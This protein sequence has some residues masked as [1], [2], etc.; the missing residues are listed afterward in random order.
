M[1]RLF[2]FDID[3]FVTRDVKHWDYEN[4]IPRWD[5]I[6]F[7]RRLSKKG[8]GV[9][10]QSH[11][12]RRD[13]EATKDW[14]AKFEVP[15]DK[16]ELLGPTVKKD[17]I[18]WDDMNTIIYGLD[19]LRFVVPVDIATNSMIRATISASAAASRIAE[20]TKSL[21]LATVGYVSNEFETFLSTIL[22]NK[23]VN[24]TIKAKFISTGSGSEFLGDNIFE[25]C[26]C[27]SGGINSICAKEIGNADQLLLYI[28]YG[29]E[30]DNFAFDFARECGAVRFDITLPKRDESWKYVIP[31]RNFI[32]AT[33]A[34]LFSN[35]I[36]IAISGNS[37]SKFFERSS[38][39]LS[40]Y[41]NRDITVRSPFEDDTKI[42]AI[43][44]FLH[45]G[46]ANILKRTT[47]CLHPVNGKSC[48]S[49]EACVLNAIALERFDLCDTKNY[50]KNPFSSKNF[51]ERV[52]NNKIED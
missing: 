50:C 3:R 13:T 1:N 38:R 48:G 11:R 39:I 16:L 2:V 41:Y 44:N 46:D 37:D 28:G 21:K 51:L 20:S 43:R 30:Y 18:V 35:D 47:N 49:C 32:F 40:K 15:Y 14:F 22:S 42:S 6:N 19:G 4:R 31:G 10:F 23:S 27:F 52:L 7:V 45:T 26:L 34:A 33:I 25:S 12:L 17:D 29:S 36:V 24:K 5:R 9:K 8:C